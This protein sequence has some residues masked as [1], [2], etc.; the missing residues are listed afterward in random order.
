MIEFLLCSCACWEREASFEWQNVTNRVWCRFT[1][2]DERLTWKTMK[3][4]LIFCECVL[5]PCLP[6]QNLFQSSKWISSL[7]WFLQL[8]D[9]GMDRALENGSFWESKW[10]I[11]YWVN[12]EVTCPFIFG[13]GDFLQLFTTALSKAL[14]SAGGSATELNPGCPATAHS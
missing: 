11:C 2:C 14:N 8:C 7:A 5:F 9:A 10:I 13:C 1:W 3:L 6:H 4:S 12:E